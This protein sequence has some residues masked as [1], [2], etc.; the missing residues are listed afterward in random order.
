MPTAAC[1]LVD[2]KNLQQNHWVKSE[3]IQAFAIQLPVD[4]VPSLT[5]SLHQEQQGFKNWSSWFENSMKYR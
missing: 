3:R 4:S 5:T 2:D 1:Q